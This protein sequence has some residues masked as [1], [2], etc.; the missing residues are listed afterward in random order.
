MS[1]S[2]AAIFHETGREL[3][4]RQLARP[5][6]GGAEVLVRVLGCTLCGSDLHTFDGRRDTPVP[7]I[8]GHEIV[9]EISALGDA[10]PA[11]DLAG[12]DL[13]IGDR[14][15]W[16]IVANCGDCFFCRRGLPQNGLGV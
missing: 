5:E 10:A 4:M 13:R 14:V 2:L 8:L 1:T 16:S 12:N 3:E 6:P 7:T 9:G 11:R 15:T